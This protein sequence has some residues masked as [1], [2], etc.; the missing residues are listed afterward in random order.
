[1][2]VEFP[3]SAINEL[4]WVRPFGDNMMSAF[5]TCCQAPSCWPRSRY[6][7]SSESR[8]VWPDRPSLKAG[9]LWRCNSS[10]R[11]RAI[12]NLQKTRK[13]CHQPNYRVCQG[14]WPSLM[15]ADEDIEPQNFWASSK[16]HVTTTYLCMQFCSNYIGLSNHILCVATNV[17]LSLQIYFWTTACSHM[18]R[19]ATRLGTTAL[20]WSEPKK[21]IWGPLL[22]PNLDRGPG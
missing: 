6:S 19:M 10:S 17:T 4:S 1:M 14:L 2:K 15:F 3:S 21:K 8:I 13:S 12:S 16:S 22:G 9:C 18:W 11:T 5:H 20:D 7:G